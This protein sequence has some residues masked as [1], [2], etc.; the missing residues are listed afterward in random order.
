MDNPIKQL[1]G[2]FKNGMK[3]NNFR[4]FATQLRI[5]SMYGG[6]ILKKNP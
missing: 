5:T 4:Y 2:L 6:Y 3:C 1:S